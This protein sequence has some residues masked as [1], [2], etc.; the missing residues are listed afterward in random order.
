MRR[1]NV[2]RSLFVLISTGWMLSALPLA[3]I[4]AP[5]DAKKEATLNLSGVS[6]DPPNF[7]INVSGIAVRDG[8][9]VIGSDEGSS[10]Q[11]FKKTG[12]HTYQAT[13]SGPI[14]LDAPST[15]VDIEGIAWDDSH[16][17]VVGS[18]SLA[19]KEVK[20]KETVADNHKRLAD[21][22]KDEPS[23]K[24]IFRLKLDSNGALVAGSI[25]HITLDEVFKHHPILER[26]RHIPSKENGIDIEAIAV[27]G[28]ELLVGFRGPSLRG[29]YIPVLA[30]KFKDGRFETDAIQTEDRFLDLGGRGI[31][32]MT[33]VPGGGF[34]VLGGPVGDEP[35]P[36]QLYFWDGQDALPGK[37]APGAK[38]GVK[39]ICRIS[40]PDVR[41]NGEKV[42]VVSG[43]YV[44]C[45]ASSAKAEGVAFVEMKGDEIRFIIVYDTATNGAPTLF[46]CPFVK[47]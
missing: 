47:S 1:R 6:I 46:S 21:P 19:R 25:E 16:V 28:D 5:P 42:T 8:L 36:Y 45:D 39:P 44:S 24:Q 7:N 26:F 12:P 43:N 15:E 35:T 2:P 40:C 18:H 27:N 29:P 34:L 3:A 37:N 17:Y 13:A 14:Q 32:D 22:P 11:V 31:R 30:L 9:L 33:A 38:D 10:I 4:C 41:L 23:R 20:D